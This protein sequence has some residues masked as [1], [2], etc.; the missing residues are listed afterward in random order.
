L[1]GQTSPIAHFVVRYLGRSGY[2]DISQ[3]FSALAGPHPRSLQP[4]AFALGCGRRRC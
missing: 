3:H 2:L 1:N 4:R